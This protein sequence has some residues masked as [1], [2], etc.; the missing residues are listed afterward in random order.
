MGTNS[1][2]T[3][4]IGKKY[5]SIYC[6]WDGYLSHNGEKLLKYYNSQERAESLVELGDLSL[7]GNF[8]T[9][10]NGHSF[11]TPVEDY[12]IYYGRDR[13]ETNVD[14]IVAD[15]FDVIMD[16][17][18]REYNYLFDDGYW[19]VDIKGDLSLLTRDLIE[20]EKHV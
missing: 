4:K 2:I 20:S 19:Y 10:L 15:N 13:G 17:N 7:L 3:V 11:D 14:P 6:H 12:C 18:E 8:N 5:H 9:K 1:S 16:K